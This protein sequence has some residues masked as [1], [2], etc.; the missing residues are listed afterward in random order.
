MIWY[1][2]LTLIEYLE[3]SLPEWDSNIRCLIFLHIW[4]LVYACEILINGRILQSTGNTCYLREGLIELKR[5][6][7]S[8]ICS[9]P[10]LK[11]N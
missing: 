7:T 10:V 6:L 2:G 5:I 3:T 9:R 1:H 4:H 11:L 8:T